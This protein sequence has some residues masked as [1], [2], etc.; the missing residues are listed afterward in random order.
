[1][2]AE[3]LSSGELKHGTLALISDDMPVVYVATLDGESVRKREEKDVERERESQ[4]SGSIEGSEGSEDDWQAGETEEDRQREREREEDRERERTTGGVS[5]RGRVKDALQQVLARRKSG[6][7]ML[8]IVSESLSPLVDHIRETEREAERERGEK[9]ETQTDRE[10]GASIVL[11]LPGTSHASLRS[12]LSVIGL[13]VLA[14]LLAVA[15]GH[16]VDKPRCLAKCVT[17]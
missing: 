3:G 17:V 15:R 12:V 4:M 7:N 2:H 9:G 16:S 10:E 14:Y 1:M 11:V 5:H 8:L 13:Q 6:S